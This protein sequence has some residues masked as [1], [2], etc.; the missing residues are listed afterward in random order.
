TLTARIDSDLGL[1]SNG[2]AA[3]ILLQTGMALR[4]QNKSLSAAY[5]DQALDRA[6]TVTSSEE[7][8]V[9][10]DWKPKSEDDRLDALYR[11]FLRQQEVVS[12]RAIIQVADHDLPRA[13]ELV[14]RLPRSYAG[15]QL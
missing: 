15:F 3:L 7:K 14:S 12:K 10:W 13:E 9:D 5:I 6:G 2:E 8:I 11:E 1:L 4:D